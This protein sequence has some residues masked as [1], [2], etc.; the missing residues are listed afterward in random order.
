MLQVR[1]RLVMKYFLFASHDKLVPLLT[2]FC[3]AVMFGRG[4]L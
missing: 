1:L 2:V 4:S 3:E